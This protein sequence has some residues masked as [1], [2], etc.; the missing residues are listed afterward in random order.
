MI[1]NAIRSER[2]TAGEPLPSVREMS[3]LQDVPVATLQHAR[4]VLAE[5]KLIVIRQGRTAIVTGDVSIERHPVRARRGRDHNCRHAGCKPHV[6]KPL[7]TRMLPR[8]S[9]A[10]CWTGQPAWSRAGSSAG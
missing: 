9:P 6:C 5:E 8:A 10:R 2:L 4:A 7:T 1:G 3:D